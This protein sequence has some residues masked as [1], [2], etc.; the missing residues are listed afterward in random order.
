MGGTLLEPY[1]SSTGRI[2]RFS[3][4]LQLGV[5]KVLKLPQAVKAIA[6]CKKIATPFHHSSKSSYIL[7][8]KQ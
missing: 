8:E 7:K 3:Q 4:T 6:C 2:F 1:D 5:Q